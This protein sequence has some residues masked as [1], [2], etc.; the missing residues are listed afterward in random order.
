MNHDKM[1]NI[2]TKRGI[3]WSSFEIYSGVAGFIDYGPL[4]AMLK[5]NVMQKWREIYLVNEG[6]YE[7]ESPTVTPEEVLIASGHVNNFTDPMVQ[8]SECMDVFRL[9]HIVEEQ[10][11]LSVDGYTNEELNKAVFE[12]N[13]ACS[14]CGGK[15]SETWN[16]N[17][18][19]RTN[20]GPKGNKP[21]YMRPETAQGIFIMFK[22]LSRFFKN[23]LPFGVV[24][25]GKAYR[26]EISPRQG[27]IRLREFTQAEAEIFVHPKDKTHP[28]F[29]KIADEVFVL[30][31]AKNQTEDNEP[32]TLTG[33]EALD[34][35][36]VANEILIYEIYLA[37]KFLNEIGIPDSVLRIR[38]HLQN[39]MAHYANDSWDVELKTDKYGWVE[40]IGIAD[41]GDYDLLAHSK[42][43]GEDL[44]IYVEYDEAKTIK[45]TIIKPN[46]KKLGRKFRK[47]SMQ[48]VD[49]LKS[50]NPLKIKEK[51]KINGLYEV[52]N[53]FS[54]FSIEKDDLLFEE[55][56][57]EVKGEKIIPH[58]IEPSFGI[59]RIIYGLL[60]HSFNS[61][62]IK[63]DGEDKIKDYFKFTPAVSPIK[64]AVFPLVKKD[65]LP[66]IAISIK[67][68]L[69]LEG[70]TV[71]YESSG[72]IG[73]RYARSDEIGIPLAITI[74][75]E[76]LEDDRVTVRNRDS[77]KQERVKIED[78]NSYIKKFYN[79]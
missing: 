43:S 9:D 27:V 28:K 58:V 31:S 5:N 24:Q 64:V 36:I 1:I 30:Y 66:E 3:L 48:I 34:K 7:I 46:M 45:R 73:R 23:K 74:D 68:N 77:E 51:L 20:I 78:L 44:S 39:E 60:L 56:E 14:S 18:M 12:E 15:L 50:E 47:N 2:S 41:R 55:I 67:D 49:A 22:R 35:K 70:F 8:C 79:N 40:I 69:R 76:T 63:E 13:V 61:I 72:T 10:T 11:N 16:F 54:S 4:G 59:D 52:T 19:F 33:Q 37:K 29:E 65:R 75:F 57:E 17:L 26:N 32:I 42:Y 6:F 25:L 53:H 38:Q 71:E 62:T 21:G